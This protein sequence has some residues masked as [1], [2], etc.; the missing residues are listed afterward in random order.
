M[1]DDEVDLMGG[2]AVSKTVKIPIAE[3]LKI[4]PVLRAKHSGN[5]SAFA[6]DAFEAYIARKEAEL[7]HAP[8]T[9]K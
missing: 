7:E 6:R 1:D 5:F 4:E 2:A 3:W 9:S 8:A